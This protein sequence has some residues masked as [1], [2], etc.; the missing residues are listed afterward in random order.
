MQTACGRDR[1]A[2]KQVI[3]KRQCKYIKTI[4]ACHSISKAAQKLYVSQPSLSRLVKKI[5][6]E[7]GVTL[8]DR[9]TI[10][11]GLTPAGERY[12]DYIDQFQQLEARMQ[13]DFAAMGSGMTNQL[14]I[15]TLNLLGTYVLP[16]IVPHFAEQ[17]PS[18]DLQIH[19]ESSRNLLYQVETGK[20]DLAITNLKP[21]PELFDYHILCSDPIVL[22][23]P[24]DDKMR[25]RFPDWS[26][27]PEHPLTV[28]FSSLEDGNLIVLR[29][30]QNMRI[31]AE[32]VCRNLSFTPHRVTESPSLASALSLVGSK[33]GMTFICP[34]YVR[35]IRP[36]TPIIYFSTGEVQSV[37]DIV[38]VFRKDPS[39]T[40]VEKFCSCAARSLNYIVK[41]PSE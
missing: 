17:Y 18:V 34:S 39:N 1:K 26:G 27:D 6:D 19:E 40:L 22:A 4:A 37:T 11:L 25:R 31:A 12:L 24:Y 30:W 33:R 29:P 3:D 2:E 5:E 32:T 28:D 21:N 14:I 35:C 9:D 23:V 41:T 16:K 13:A 7:L 36:N 38:A 8:F 15:T 10:P 20:A